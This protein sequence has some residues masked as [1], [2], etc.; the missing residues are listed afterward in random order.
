MQPEGTLRPAIVQDAETGRVLMLSWIAYSM[1]RSARYGSSTGSSTGPVFLP[2]SGWGGS[3]GGG[4][5]G[6]FSGGGGS[7]GGGGA[8]G[9][10]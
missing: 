10:W 8:S 5:R 9:G 7:F 4:G 6:G 1:Y 3:T 2:G